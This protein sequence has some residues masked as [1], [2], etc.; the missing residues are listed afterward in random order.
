VADR[1]DRL[2]HDAEVGQGGLEVGALDLLR[3][4]EDAAALRLADRLDD[5]RRQ[6]QVV[7]GDHADAG[8]QVAGRRLGPGGAV[9]PDWLADLDVVAG[10]QEDVLDRLVVDEGAVGAADVDEAV[11]LGGLA[12]LGVAAGDLGVVQPDAVAG[13]AADAELRVGQVELFA[14]IGALD[15][16]D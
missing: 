10:L 4:G 15:D 13:V 14:F 9:D 8:G 5:G 3:L 16:D 1:L 2:V 11:T 6:L 12:E 7:A